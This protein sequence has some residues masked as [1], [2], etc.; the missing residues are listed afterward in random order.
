MMEKRLTV[1][2][3]ELWESV[4]KGEPP[5]EYVRFNPSS[6][7]DIWPQCFALK[8]EPGASGGRIEYIGKQIVSLFAGLKEGSHLSP[9]MKIFPA[10]QLIRRFP[11]VV[12]DHAILTDEGQFV[13]NNNK[14]VKYRSCLLPFG[15]KEGGI[16]H[17]VMGI[18]WR[19]F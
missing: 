13:N 10:A 7:Q 12:T 1:R 18:S 8:F 5:P 3:S 4:A 17:V 6:I 14:V 2:M 11:E 15:S 9:Q 19:E 16:T